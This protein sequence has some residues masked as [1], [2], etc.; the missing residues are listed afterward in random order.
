MLLDYIYNRGKRSRVKLK[1][2]KPIYVLIG[3]V[4]KPIQIKTCIPLIL[5]YNSP[6]IALPR[7][8]LTLHDTNA[9]LPSKLYP[10]KQSQQLEMQDIR[11]VK[12]TKK[13]ANPVSKR[14]PKTAPKP[15]S[16]RHPKRT[17]IYIRTPSF[18]D[19]YQRNLIIF[20]IIYFIHAIP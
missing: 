3:Q 2:L 16:V 12:M 13:T 6:R 20:I 8:C 5:T 1:K 15:H 19:V 10:I 11:V 9:S 18:L 17:S 4:E 7:V 14:V